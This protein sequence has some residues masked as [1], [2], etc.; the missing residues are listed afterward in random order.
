MS[1]AD[2]SVSKHSIKLVP[3]PTCS[4]YPKI[5]NSRILK[6]RTVSIPEEDIEIALNP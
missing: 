5:S 2:A 3:L 4:I 1:T 6:D